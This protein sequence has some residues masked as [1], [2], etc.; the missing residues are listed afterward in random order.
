MGKQTI[1][2]LVL[3]IVFVILAP[4]ILLGFT[5]LG[6]SMAGKS[7][8]NTEQTQ[9]T[10]QTAAKV[11]EENKTTDSNI[12]KANNDKVTNDSNNSSNN[13]NNSTN[14]NTS[15]Q[16]NSNQNNTN[17]SSNKAIASQDYTVKAGDTLFSI[18]AAAYG[19]NNTQAGVEKIKEANNMQNNNLAAGQ[20]I[21][22]PNL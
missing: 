17:S 22:I 12:P 15:N 7:K 10:A 5:S 18:A 19:E 2:N 9:T 20:K 8:Q 16:E 14:N 21:Q 6:N 11:P 3:S 4:A 1:K 13:S